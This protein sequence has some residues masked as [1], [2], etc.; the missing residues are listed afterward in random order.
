MVGLCVRSQHGSVIGTEGAMS[1]NES[2][3]CRSLLDRIT[4]HRLTDCAPTNTVAPR[5]GQE[6]DCL[7]TDV[8]GMRVETRRD[9]W[10]LLRTSQNRDDGFRLPLRSKW[11]SHRDFGAAP[12]RGALL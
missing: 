8:G 12:G 10:V 6:V 11:Q 2:R 4:N 5:P 9:R 3:A 1:W 7:C